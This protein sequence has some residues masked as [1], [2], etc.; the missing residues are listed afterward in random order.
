M[1]YGVAMTYGANPADITKTAFECP[2]CGAYTSQHWYKVLASPF[3]D[4]QH[5]TVPNAKWSESIR[6]AEE[7][8]ADLKHNL[9]AWGAKME[10]GLPFFTIRDSDN[11]TEIEVENVYISQCFVCH[12]PSIWVHDSVNFPSLKEG[13][14][15]HAD[16]PDDVRRDFDEARGILGSS[17]RGAAALLRLCIQKLCDQLGQEGKKIDDAIASLLAKGLDPMIGRALDSVRVIG[18]EAVHPGQMDLRDD[19]ATAAKLFGLVNI[20]VDR[21]ISHPKKVQEIY[22]TLPESKRKA[23]EERNAKAATAIKP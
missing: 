11:W 23:I 13:P 21:M 15:A 19:Q 2:Y 17:E 5:P 7:L 16:M 8:G 1:R 14:A 12:K 18:N 6:A 22:G 20:I 4:A 3:K 10:T 9:L